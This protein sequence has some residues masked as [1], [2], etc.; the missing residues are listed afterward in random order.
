MQFLKMQATGNDFLILDGQKYTAPAKPLRPQMARHYCQRIYGFGADGF[1]VLEKTAAGIQWDFY[2]SDGSPANMCGNAARA[3]G[4]YLMDQNRGDR[5][6]FLTNVGRVSAKRISQNEIEVEF[7]IPNTPIKKVIS[8]EGFWIDTGVPHVVLIT[9]S[10]QDVSLLRTVGQD[11]KSQYS[12]DGINVT[13]FIPHA[14]NEIEATTFERGVEDFTLSCG[15][16]ALAAARIHLQQKDGACEVQVPGGKLHVTFKG[17]R[18]ILRG[19]ACIV[20]WCAPAE[21][22]SK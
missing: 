2:N 1:L 15:T 9:N 17:N 16:G 18:A 14:P 4:R 12:Q 10:L 19:E 7:E 13:F 5:A 6:D 20:G 11:V 22:A 3:V 8:P 21:G